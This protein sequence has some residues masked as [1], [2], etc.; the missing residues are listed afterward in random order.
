MNKATC[1]R[2]VLMQ[3]LQVAAFAMHEAVLYL[4]T[5]PC[6]PVALTEYNQYKLQYQRA[7]AQYVEKVGPI[8]A[9][10]AGGDRWNWI[11]CPWPWQLQ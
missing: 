10:N 5:H 4:D 3:N 6:D 2:E 1:E 9:Q 11:D 7:C 8:T